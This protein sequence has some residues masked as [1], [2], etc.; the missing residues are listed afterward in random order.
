MCKYVVGLVSWKPEN[1]GRMWNF[2]LRKLSGKLTIHLVLLDS[3][4]NK[5]NAQCV[6]SKV[7]I[8]NACNHISTIKCHFSIV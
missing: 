7:H 5:F 2:M 8:P 6:T 1:H 3:H 4:Q